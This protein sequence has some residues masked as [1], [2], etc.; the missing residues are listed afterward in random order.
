MNYLF[1]NFA[2]YGGIHT[3]IISSVE[4]KRKL[5]DS[6]VTFIK[7][8]KENHPNIYTIT[9]FILNKEHYIWESDED[10]SE[11]DEDGINTYTQCSSCG[12]GISI[13]NDA[14]NGFCIH[15]PQ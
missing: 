10:Y 14:G 4:L 3:E 1:R 6:E 15:C 2:I 7:D 9:Q 12:R 8:F 5:E 11:E 13:S